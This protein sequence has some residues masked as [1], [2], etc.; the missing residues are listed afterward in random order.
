MHHYHSP[1]PNWSPRW[2]V[3]TWAAI[4]L[5]LASVIYEGPPHHEVG[6]RHALPDP[7]VPQC[8]AVEWRSG[9]YCEIRP[10]KRHY[11]N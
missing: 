2:L 10:V 3:G 6:V 1:L 4:V 7:Y 11:K 5:M 8:Y 9:Q